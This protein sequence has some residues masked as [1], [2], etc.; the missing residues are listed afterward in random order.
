MPA[1]NNHQIHVSSDT[2]LIR[3]KL[4]NT[5]RPCNNKFNC[6]DDN[7]EYIHFSLNSVCSDVILKNKCNRHKCNAIHIKYCKYKN[8]KSC[9]YLHIEDIKSSYHYKFWVFK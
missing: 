7:C 1:Y 5:S 8:C 3:Y 9:K 4:T 2:E 6:D